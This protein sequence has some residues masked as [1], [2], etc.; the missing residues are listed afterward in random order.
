[1]STATTVPETREHGAGDARDQLR[2]TGLGR[3]LVDA[4]RRFH[5]ADGTSYARALGLASLLS[6]I[7][8]LIGVAGLTATLDVGNAQGTLADALRSLAPGPAGGTLS[9]ALRAED[10]GTVAIVAGLIGMLVSG[11][12]AMVHLERG[13]NR[14]YGVEEHRTLRRRYAIA[15]ATATSA[16]VLLMLGLLVIASA[17]AVGDPSA[18]GAGDSTSG[19]WE[20]LRWP[21]AV[22]LVALPMTVIFRFGPNRRQPPFSWLLSGTVVAVALWIAVTLALTLFYEHAGALGETYGPLLGVVALLVWAYLTAVAVLYG[23]A[24]AAQLEAV[25]AGQPDSARDAGAAPLT[26]TWSASDRRLFGR[27]RSFGR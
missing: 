21:V 14:I 23:L 10:A 3:L 11:T 4:G 8:G 20:I 15:F 19:V 18:A 6:L 16:G 12:L 25:R 22:L 7:P 17:G 9:E 13:A 24:V 2:R 27:R 5:A 1:M 26:R